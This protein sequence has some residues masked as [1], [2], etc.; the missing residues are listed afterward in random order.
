[1]RIVLMGQAA[2]G[3]RSLEALLENGENVVAVYAPADKGGRSDPLKDAAV[4]KGLPIFQPTTYKSDE[5]FA[6]YK[7]LQP[8]LTILAFVTDII[9]SRF[10]D[11]ATKGAIC[12]HPSILP[13]HRGASAI[14][15]AV[16]MG[17]SR[18]GLTIFWPDGGIDTG[19]I[20]LQKEVEIGENDTT[21]TLYF[22]NLF[23]MGINAI[24]EAV[25]L[26][27]E[28]KAPRIPQDETKATY[29]APCDNKVAA[30]DWQKTAQEIYNM[31]RGC[32][33]QPG[34]YAYWNG[35]IIR[36]FGAV[37]HMEPTD[38]APGAI[39]NVDQKAIH[40]AV[41]GG[42]LA[43]AKVRPGKGAKVDSSEW[44]A[45]KGVKVGDR[46]GTAP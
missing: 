16:I 2:F 4:A 30:I 7:E 11:A 10:F 22:N 27:K 26:I 44:A 35:E 24:V 19:P 42:I 39:V 12:Y 28:N 17:D 43:V 34:A 36:F 38:S 20:L 9:P 3:V 31:L 18:T 1:M 37:L 23:P 13:R 21:G 46:F 41:P 6:Q 32:D 45:E 15:W 29:E 25:A 33:P 5:V 8:D 40:V 14:N